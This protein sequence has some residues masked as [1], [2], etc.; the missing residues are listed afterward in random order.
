MHN[1][2]RIGPKI[3]PCGTPHTILKK[4]DEVLFIDANDID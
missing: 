4:Y 3:Y 1:R 2:N